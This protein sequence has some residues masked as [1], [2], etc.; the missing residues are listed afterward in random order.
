MAANHNHFGATF[1]IL[2]SDVPH[3]VEDGEVVTAEIVLRGVGLMNV[4]RP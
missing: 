3:I 1:H 4:N 2:A